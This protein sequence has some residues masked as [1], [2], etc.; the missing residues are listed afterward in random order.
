MPHF[1]DVQLK[2]LLD[3]PNETLEVEYKQWLDFSQIEVRADVARHIAAL[4]NYGGGSIVFGFTDA[5]EFAGPN[6]YSATSFDRDLI[7]SIVKK[8]LEPSF[9][10]DVRR[11]TSSAGNEHP[12]VIVPA[13][14]ASPICARANGPFDGKK[15]VGI[16]QGVHYTRKPGPASAQIQNAA[17]WSPIIRR[18]AMHDRSAIFSAL[19]AAL[20]GGG[21]A[22]EATSDSLRRWH[23][24]AH[25][26]FLKDAENNSTHPNVAK[27]HWQGSYAIELSDRQILD[28]GLLPE[29]LR[30]IHH[31]VYDTVNSGWNMIDP[32]GVVDLRP[33]FTVDPDSGLGES[34]FLEFS[35]LRSNVGVSISDL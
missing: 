11:F 21:P 14:G 34:D 1:D 16:V 35:A 22:S 30:Q 6:P 29:V 3:D 18:C 27:W 8:Y 20:R 24:A 28:I 32:Q 9:Q 17:E 5:M 31:E 25:A 33:V 7:S 19:D 23:D 26:V 12:I 15:T 10:C 4:A 13:H 2:A